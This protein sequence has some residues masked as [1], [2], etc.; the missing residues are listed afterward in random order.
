MNSTIPTSLAGLRKDSC[1]NLLAKDDFEKG[2][3]IVK[4][5]PNGP[6]CLCNL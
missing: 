4:I 2:W 3:T 6:N 5:I 1:G